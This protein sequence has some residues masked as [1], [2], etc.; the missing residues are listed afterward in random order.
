MRSDCASIAFFAL[1]LRLYGAFMALSRRS[2]CAEIVRAVHTQ[3]RRGRDAA[4]SP[5]KASAVDNYC[6]HLA[7]LF[8]FPGASVALYE[9][10][11]CPYCDPNA[12]VSNAEWRRLF[13]ACSKCAPSVGVVCDATTMLWRCLRPY[14]ALMD[15][16]NFLWTPW[17][18]QGLNEH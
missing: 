9:M 12:L 13:W 3:Y 2:H 18:W 8:R 15:V 10:L 14:C 1:S 16:L 6:V 7:Y 4:Q 17:E 5:C 11:R